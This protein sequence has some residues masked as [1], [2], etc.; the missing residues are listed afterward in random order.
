VR[1][2]ARAPRRGEEAARITGG[3]RC[4]WRPGRAGP[5]RSRSGRWKRGRRGR[6]PAP[7]SSRP[8]RRG[9]DAE[10]VALQTTTSAHLAGLE[11]AGPVRDPERLGGVGGDPAIASGLADVQA[12]AV[13]QA[14]AIA[15]SWF[16]CWM[17][18]CVV[19]VDDGAPRGLWTHAARSPDAVVG[20][21]LEPRPLGPGGDADVSRASTVGDLVGLRRVVEGRGAEAEL[22]G[23]V[24]LT[25]I[26]SA[27]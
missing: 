21:Q 15:A 26:S 18:V 8:S 27:R 6:R 3:L 10:R 11:R 1:R 22:A 9:V 17:M 16:R 20:L 25:A 5:A 24:E 23:D 2:A 14:R 4:G 19:R 7:P 12:R 13:A